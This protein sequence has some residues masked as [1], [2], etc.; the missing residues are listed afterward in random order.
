MP[1]EGR[2]EWPKEAHAL[3]THLLQFLLKVLIIKEQAL[4]RHLDPA[5]GKL[6]RLRRRCLVLLLAEQVVH[7]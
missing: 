4:A 7:K 3:L 6:R 5:L 1:L 2:V